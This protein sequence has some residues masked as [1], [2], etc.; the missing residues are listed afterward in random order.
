MLELLVGSY[1]ISL[2][3]LSIIAAQYASRL[4]QEV[5]KV[6]LTFWQD[7]CVSSEVNLHNLDGDHGGL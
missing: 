5:I 3:I 7:N 4:V 6:K 1:N 2:A